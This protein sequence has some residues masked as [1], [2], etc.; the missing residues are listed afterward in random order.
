MLEIDFSIVSEKTKIKYK[1]FSEK[2]N[3]LLQKYGEQDKKMGL[4]RL[5]DVKTNR[6]E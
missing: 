6:V 3:E 1:E 4:T 5:E 2:V